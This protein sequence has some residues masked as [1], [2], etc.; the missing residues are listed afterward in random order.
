M[1]IREDNNYNFEGLQ[2]RCWD[3]AKETLKIIEKNGKRK[4]FMKWLEEYFFSHTP[5]IREVND[6]LWF[7]DN[8]IFDELDIEVDD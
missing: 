3:G 1:Y 6:L 7:D 4:E 5:T 8:Y 2:K